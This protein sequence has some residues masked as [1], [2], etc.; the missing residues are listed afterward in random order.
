MKKGDL[1]WV[2]L[3][4]AAVGFMLAP[5]TRPLFEQWTLARPYLMGFIK[6]ALLATMGELLA[7]R[8][9]EGAYRRPPKLIWRIAI[10]GLIGLMIT[11]MFKVF[12]GGVNYALQSG[13]LPFAGSKLAFAF[14]TS[15]LMNLFFAPTFM[16]FH[17]Y[18]DTYLALC[19]TAPKVT[20]QDVV[21][22][23]DWQRFI[24][25][26]V[27]KTIPFFWIPA[28]TLTFLLPPQYRV[29]AAAF[30]SVALGMMLSLA[31]RGAAVNGNSA[32]ERD[33]ER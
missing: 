16:A 19:D 29:I 24:G 4:C 18:T 8:I 31:Q 2:L 20:L 21:A 5:A 9:A 28:H 22:A 14:F 15:S 32:G 23:I 17:K 6:F 13:Y 1:I 3:M 33:D 10:W 12:A 26:V 27:L 7:L 30:L 25:F 11:L